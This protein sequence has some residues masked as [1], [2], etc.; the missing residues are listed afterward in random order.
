M[1]KSDVVSFGPVQSRKEKEKSVATFFWRIG[2]CES[3][4]SKGLMVSTET[5]VKGEM[6]L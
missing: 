6:E 3:R 5:F 1:E 2:E 4:N